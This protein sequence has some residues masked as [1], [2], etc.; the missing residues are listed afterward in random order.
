MAN[1][2]KQIADLKEILSL[3]EKEVVSM[4]KIRDLEQ[5][6]AEFR[7]DQAEQSES[8]R[9][10]ATDVITLNRE[11]ITEI[12]RQ[13]ILSAELAD[14]SKRH[15]DSLKF[16]L[17][18][19]AKIFELAENGSEL[20]KEK[21]KADIER[22][23]LLKSELEVLKKILINAEAEALLAERRNNQLAIAKANVDGFAGAL[24]IASSVNDTWLGRIQ[25]TAESATSI[26]DAIRSYGPALR[27]TFSPANVLASIVSKVAE[28]TIAIAFEMDTT[29]AQFNKATGA[30]GEF[31]EVID[32][33]R[34]G[35]M[36]AGVGLGESAEAT[37][38]LFENFQD[39]TSI[40]REAQV[41]V[42]R[43]TALI[44]KLGISAETTAQA[45]DLSVNALGMTTDQAIITQKQIAATAQE[46]GVAPGKLAS[47]FVS[48][49]PALVQY[50]NAA[51]DV[52]KELATQSKATGVEM[53]ALVGIA[54][55]FDTF[56][57]A[58]Q[59]AGK[60]NAIL[61]GNLVNSVEL[62]NASEAERI[63]LLREGVAASGTSF[64]AMTKFE[65]MAVAN[66]AGISDMSQAAKIFG[67]TDEEFARVA[68]A[69]NAEALSVAALTEAAQHSTS[70]QEKMKLVIESLSGAALPLINV[71]QKIMNTIL[72]IN[73]SLGG[74]FIPIAT[75]AIAAV[76]TFTKVVQGLQAASTALAATKTF[77]I[78]TTATE[79]AVTNVG[80]VTRIRETT[81][82]V[83]GTVA[84][85]AL[86]AA[87]LAVIVATGAWILA[88]EGA[89]AV[90]AFLNISRGT[91]IGL[92]ITENVGRAAG[93][94]LYW[95]ETAA[96]WA[97]VVAKGAWAL[98]TAVVTGGIWALTVA[99]LA[100]PIGLL[101]AGV[102]AL[103][104]AFVAV[105]VYFDEIDAWL[106]NITGGMFELT[107]VLLMLLGPFGMIAVAVMK[108]IDHWDALAASFDS[109]DGWIQNI[110]GGFFDIYDVLLF[111]AGPI[112]MFISSARKIW[113]AWDAAAGGIKDS[114]S[115]LVNFLGTV[116][117]T[118]TDILLFP[119]RNVADGINMMIKGM[120]L[121][122]GVSIP[123]IPKFAG[124]VT[125]FGG[126][127]AMVGEKGP[128]LVSL[129]PGSNVITNENVQALSEAGGARHGAS[130]DAQA[131]TTRANERLASAVEKGKVGQ[132]GPGGVTEGTPVILELDG[133]EL[134]RF[135]LT[136]F[137]KRMKLNVV[138]N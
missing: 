86:N 102:I 47:D 101:V 93:T 98:A 56:E 89:A 14:A 137:D 5:Q 26:S 127:M 67:Q 11:Q 91:G 13:Q 61:G 121:V 88:S 110:T 133:R 109:L 114:F 59:A 63:K 35:S 73:D 71:L 42:A 19:H 28:S 125:G 21:A 16:Q 12:E 43:T 81:A 1:G 64:A 116:F 120:N 131:R 97:V 117:R 66:A 34:F 54:Q 57:G 55:Q 115:S 122:P 7:E 31:N 123:M 46:L 96:V 119:A 6:I 129:P 44:G 25:Q 107:D 30:A 103:I 24:G 138:G 8:L 29:I 134:G 100:N 69:Q 38:A 111:A 118:M 83:A 41:E 75:G 85:W 106:K 70:V 62:L 79:T 135:M 87:T 68:A 3:R 20:E 45:L 22:L 60:L 80:V 108:I 74:S 124:G 15:A 76:L 33:V 136:T 126:G 39:F 2:D 130:A 23:N 99:I 95:A 9:A 53:A 40:G 104:A 105:I 10:A 32:D 65:K 90:M 4:E 128:E 51:T 17:E 27:T 94:L 132:P 37:Q 77:L 36:Q 92:M 58:S 72:R 112:G 52:F 50:G 84:S 82:K 49:I 113:D 18:Q 48:S 78:G